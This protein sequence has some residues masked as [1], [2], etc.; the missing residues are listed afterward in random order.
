M[1]QIFRCLII[2]KYQKGEEQ[3]KK[4]EDTMSEEERLALLEEMEKWGES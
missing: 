1:F 2:N 3:W 4:E